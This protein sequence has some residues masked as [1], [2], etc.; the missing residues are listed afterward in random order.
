MTPETKGIASWY[1]WPRRAHS[2]KPEAFYDLVE[3][4][5]PA[6]WLEMFSR[7]ARIGWDTWGDEALQQRAVMDG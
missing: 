5:S 3:Q 7:R 6:P 1:V 4:V 2:Q